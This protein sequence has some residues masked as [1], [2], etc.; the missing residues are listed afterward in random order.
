MPREHGVLACEPLKMENRF[1]SQFSF[2]YTRLESI[3]LQAP[4]LALRVYPY[5]AGKIAEKR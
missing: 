1:Q 3:G 2:V 4:R 5:A